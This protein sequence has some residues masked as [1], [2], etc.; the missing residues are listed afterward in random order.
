MHRCAARAYEAELASYPRIELAMA[1]CLN[2]IKGEA[3]TLCELQHYDTVLDTALDAAKIDRQT[4]DAM[5][6]AMRESLPAFRR[7]FRAKARPFGARGRIA[8]L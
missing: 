6:T 3:L 7:Y 1:A 4:L 8:V 2:G 5:L